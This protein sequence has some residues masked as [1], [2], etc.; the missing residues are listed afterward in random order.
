MNSQTG[1]VLLANSPYV[2]DWMA[3]TYTISGKRFD[4]RLFLNP[5]GTFERW[6]RLEPD[7]ERT[8][9]GIWRHRIS[10]DI[11]Q[12]ESESPDEFGH[13][14]VSYWILTVKSCEDSNC[15]MTLRWVALASRNLP[16]LF[17]RVHLQGRAV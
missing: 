14:S 2:G 15:L 1:D 12:L 17:Y 3:S 6:T 5:D 11:L 10:D 7:R 9:R 8:D 13:T 16:I 4:Y